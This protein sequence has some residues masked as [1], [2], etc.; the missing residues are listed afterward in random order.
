MTLISHSLRAAACLQ[1]S[2]CDVLANY[3]NSYC[4]SSCY[5]G[6]LHCNGDIKMLMKL[7]FVLS[8]WGIV[9]YFL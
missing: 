4:L 7:G 9:A 6:Q 2:R 1:S 8:G 3:K 5:I